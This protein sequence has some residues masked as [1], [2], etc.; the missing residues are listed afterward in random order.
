MTQTEKEVS[1]IVETAVS[2][3]SGIHAL[4][5][6]RKLVDA[7]N[8]QDRANRKAIKWIVFCLFALIA[9]FLAWVTIGFYLRPLQPP[10]QSPVHAYVD[11]VAGQIEHSANTNYPNELSAKNIH[12]TVVLLVNIMADGKLEK[13][14]ISNSSGNP[15]L[16]NAAIRMVQKASPFPPFTEGIIKRKI[17]IMGI[18]QSITFADDKV[19]LP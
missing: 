16:D 11:L 2:R 8:E 19:V 4:R 14:D 5:A 13:I 9:A 3:S 1:E 17:D 7:E 18:T 12:G 10:E 6:I 15:I